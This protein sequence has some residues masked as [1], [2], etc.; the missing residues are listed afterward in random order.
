MGRRLCYNVTAMEFAVTQDGFTGPLGLLLELIEGKK[1]DITNVSLAAVA[2]EFLVRMEEQKL[3][4]DELA[5]FLVVAARLIYLKS[6]ELLPYLRIDD[7]EQGADALAEQLRI[8]REFVAAAERLEARF[9]QSNL[10]ARP[11]ARRQI[12]PTFVAPL[13]LTAA[14]L[15]ETYRVVLKRLEPFF[16]LQEVSME[17][18]KSVEE[19]IEELQGAIASRAS[20][21]FNDMTKTAGKKIDVVMSFLALLELL[22]RNIVRV[23]QTGTWGEIMMHRID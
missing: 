14:A 2:D 1:L 18:V 16:A 6:R 7:E 20:M 5:D 23:T 22:R 12:V 13:A 3:P 8:Y 11:V 9:M 17:R 10:Y 4:P 15:A 21:S 19:R